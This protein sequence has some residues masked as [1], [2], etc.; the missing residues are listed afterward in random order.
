ML[1]PA[2]S[3][4]APITDES[5]HEPGLSPTSLGFDLLPGAH[6]NQAPAARAGHPTPALNAPSQNKNWY[7]EFGDVVI[8][9]SHS[10]P[11]RMRT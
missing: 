6:T 10:E 11:N 7:F 1:D 5:R 3:S 4:S 2:P 8:Q 9:V